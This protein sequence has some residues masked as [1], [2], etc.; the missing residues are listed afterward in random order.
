MGEACLYA[1]WQASGHRVAAY[2]EY[3]LEIT[4]CV[5]LQSHAWQSSGVGQGSYLYHS[6]I[7][8]IRWPGEDIAVVDSR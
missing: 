5:G 1:T 7:H 8:P 3:L 2:L 6:Q 4:V